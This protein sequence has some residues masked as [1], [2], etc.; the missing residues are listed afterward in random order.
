MPVLRRKGARIQR[1]TKY[2][3][4]RTVK[5]EIVNDPLQARFANGAIG[6]GVRRVWPPGR[7]IYARVAPFCSKRSPPREPDPDEPDPSPSLFRNPHRAD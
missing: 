4:L 3:K 5:A 7:R 6:C 2:G 1:A